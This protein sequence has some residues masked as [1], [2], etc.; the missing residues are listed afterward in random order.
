MFMMF[1]MFFEPLEGWHTPGGS[2]GSLI[3]WGDPRRGGDSLSVQQQLSE[4]LKK[5]V[6]SRGKSGRRLA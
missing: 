2:D 6:W 5:G 1:A 3:T 4:R